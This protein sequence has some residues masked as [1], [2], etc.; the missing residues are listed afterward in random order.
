MCRVTPASLFAMLVKVR[1][2]PTKETEMNENN[3]LNLSE[4]L[5][6]LIEQNAVLE[7]TIKAML[8]SLQHNDVFK[9]DFATI[10]DLYIEKLPNSL[11]ERLLEI[12]E[13]SDTSEFDY[14]KS[15]K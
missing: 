10:I 8:F 6:E 1:K 3:E 11:R 2:T 9:K 15:C 7:M 12:K 5:I 4:E 14:P 13:F